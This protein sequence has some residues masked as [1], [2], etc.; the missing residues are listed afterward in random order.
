M[1]ALAIKRFAEDNTPRV[2]LPRP[3][4]GVIAALFLAIW[5]SDFHCR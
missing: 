1:G 3:A 5:Q 2:L 4:T